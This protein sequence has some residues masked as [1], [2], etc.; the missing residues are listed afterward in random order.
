MAAPFV[1]V[2]GGLAGAKGAEALRNEGYDGPIVLIGAED[3]LPYERPPLSKEYLRGEASREDPRVHPAEFYDGHD[4]ELRLGTTVEEIDLDARELVLAGGDRLEWGRLLLATGAEPRRL[5]VPG[6][7]LPGVHYLRDFADADAL[8][9]RLGPGARVAVIGAGWIG[10]EVAASARQLGAEVTLL[11]AARL[12][13]ERVLGSRASEFFADV[14]R[15]HGVDLRLGVGVE[16]IAGDRAVEAV[17]LADGERVECDLV[18]VGVG[19]APRT[20]LAERAGLEI[21]DGIA[22]GANLEASA[23]GVFAA[24][25]V[26]NAQHPF[27]GL[28]LRVEHWAN[29]LHQP[30]VAARAML[31]RPASYERLPF[32]FSDQY[33]VG[34]EY[35]GF[36]PSFDEVVLR[37]DPDDG[38]FLAFWLR[39]GRV[40]AVM[41]V[42]VWDVGAEVEALIRSRRA[43]SRDALRDPDTPLSELAGG[44]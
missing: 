14:H 2:G 16:R 20:E 27:Y 39:E 10:S 22:V 38:E 7:E 5:P 40:A 4:I 36:A 19:V 6:A 21:D 34:M 43:V 42:N 18:V 44:P 30:E 13:L 23:E 12:P 29:A 1:I 26:A 25:D 15:A 9:E 3:E 11:E 35:R 17:E 24:G 33:E 31:G 32:F 8:A 28:K 41:N 37:G